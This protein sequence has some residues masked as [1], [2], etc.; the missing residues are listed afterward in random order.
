MVNPDGGDVPQKVNHCTAFKDRYI[1]FIYYLSLEN[2]IIVF[3]P[4]PSNWNLI[5]E[6]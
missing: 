1:M 3:I 2:K 4:T 5:A 6:S